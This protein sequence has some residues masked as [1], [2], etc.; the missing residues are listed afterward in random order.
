M[1]IYTRIVRKLTR[2]QKKLL[3][4]WLKIRPKCLFIDVGASYF[5]NENWILATQIPD[6]LFLQIDPNERNLDYVDV[7][8][9][10][11]QV[12]KIPQALSEFGGSRTLYVTNVDSGSTMFEPKIS[13]DFAPRVSEELYSYLY[14]VKEKNIHTKTLIEIIQT[15]DSSRPI[16][17]KLDVQ[18]AEHEILRGAESLLRDQKIVSIELEASLLRNPIGLG[19]TKLC[20]IQPYLE[21]FGYELVDMRLI[22]SRGNIGSKE[23][24]NVGYLNECDALFVLNHRQI[25]EKNLEFRVAALF[26]LSIYGQY[27]DFFKLLDSDSELTNSAFTSP[28]SRRELM[29]LFRRQKTFF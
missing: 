15:Y 20:E 17:V 7:S 27:G 18:G 22:D 12:I 10:K 3:N 21:S 4:F 13:Q 11:A 24:E 14:P 16:I 9:V 8:P 5:Y 23:I 25:R 19:G 28:K 29:K 1:E 2:N 26:V 6:S